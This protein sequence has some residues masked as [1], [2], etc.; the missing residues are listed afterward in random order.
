MPEVVS[1]HMVS[2]SADFFAEV[3]VRDLKEYE[4]LLT[5]RLLVLP[6]IGDVRSNFSI[7]R[8]KSDAPLP[9]VSPDDERGLK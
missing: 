4:K 7:R 6:M 5:E 2:G 3:V 8:I 1:C 9:F